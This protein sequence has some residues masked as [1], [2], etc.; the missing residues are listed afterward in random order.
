MVGTGYASPLPVRLRRDGLVRN[1]LIYDRQ[2]RLISTLVAIAHI[3]A[4]E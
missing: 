1:F 3:I 4:E 2:Q